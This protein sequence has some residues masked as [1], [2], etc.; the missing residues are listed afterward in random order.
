MTKNDK[1]PCIIPGCT[2][3]SCAHGMCHSCYAGARLRIV[4]G[5]TTW[6]ELEE[7]GL[8][9]KRTHRAANPSPFEAAF[10]KMKDAP[11]TTPGGE[12]TA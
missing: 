8:A 2:R 1:Q 6:A 10:L 11:G 7:A 5:L 9:V 12:G 3:K 4:R